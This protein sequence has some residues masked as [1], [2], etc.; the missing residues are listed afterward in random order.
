MNSEINNVITE[1]TAQLKEVYSDDL[2]A[3][4]LYGSAAGTNYQSGVSDINVLVILENSNAA[5]MFSLGKALKSILQKNR[6]SPFIMTREEFTTSADVFPLEYCDILE[7]NSV[8]YGNSDILKIKVNMANLR[9]E[10]EEKLRGAVGD[11]RSMLI[12][13]SGS[14][15]T[16]KDL[17]LSWSGIGNIIFRGLLRLKNINCSGMDSKAI[18]AEVEKTYDVKLEAFLLL[19]DLRQSKKNLTVEALA[20]VDTLLEPLK[21][22]VRTVDAM[23]GGAK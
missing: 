15:K 11:L 20:F 10:L 4:I 22:L 12:A 23:D 1:F 2:L 6:I 9:F 7:N 21:A 19:N 18:L 13:S 16:L 8:V 3:V 17:I 5:K 14:E